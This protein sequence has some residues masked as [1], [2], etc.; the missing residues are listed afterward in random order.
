MKGTVVAQV[1]D[2]RVVEVREDHFALECENENALG[3]TY[4]SPDEW[5]DETAAVVLFA[6]R[7]QA[8]EA[9]VRELEAQTGTK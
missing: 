9:R 5:W 3:E 6:K 2:V 8:L 1:E 7:I 4:W